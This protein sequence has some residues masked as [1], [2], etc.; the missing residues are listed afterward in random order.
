MGAKYNKSVAQTAL[1]YYI[2][3]NIVVIP[4]SSNKE[5]MKQNFDIFDFELSQDDME[6]ISTLDTG[7]SLFFSHYDPKTVELMMEWEKMF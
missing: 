4:K 6:Q 7:K 3:R 5:R 1:R 2:Q